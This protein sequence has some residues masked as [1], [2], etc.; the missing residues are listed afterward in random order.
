MQIFNMFETVKEL[1][2]TALYLK[3]PIKRLNIQINRF[4]RRFFIQGSSIL[5]DLHDISSYRQI[6]IQKVLKTF[7][8][9]Q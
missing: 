1:N 9:E 8:K 6:R 7:D 5:F 3:R 4:K 2:L